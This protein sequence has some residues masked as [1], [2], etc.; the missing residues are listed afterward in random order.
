M[1]P[2]NLLYRVFTNAGNPL[3]FFVQGA[4]IGSGPCLLLCGP[5]IIP[6]IAG[7][8]R[9]WLEGLRITLLFGLGRFFSYTL[10]GG[11]VGYIGSYLFQLFYCK[12]WGNVVWLLAGA[13]IVLFGIMIILGK[14][15]NNPLCKWA[16]GPRGVVLLGL[17]LGFSP[18]LPLIG[19]LTEIMFVAEKVHQG[20]ILGAA[21]GLGTMISPLLFLGPVAAALPAR[22]IKSERG[23]M[24]INWLCG[25]LLAGYGLQMIIRSGYCL[26]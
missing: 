21:F 16:N 12:V 25:L 7:K 2:P 4:I 24:L 19:V 11:V 23:R 15:V 5:I 6:Y 10:L 9:N 22:L 8:Q 3:Y 14:G 26:K 13:L 18:C 17:L 1:T 20:F